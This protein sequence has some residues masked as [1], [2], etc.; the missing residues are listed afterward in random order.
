M[1]VSSTDGKYEGVCY[2]NAYSP[3]YVRLDLA[4]GNTLLGIWGGL[5]CG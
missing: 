1:G 5:L 3:R 4:K 2:S